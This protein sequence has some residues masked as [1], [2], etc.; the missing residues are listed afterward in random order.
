MAIETAI[1]SATKVMT[2]G[3]YAESQLMAK[4]SEGNLDRDAFLKLFT[5]QL[6]NQDPLSPM[7]NEAFV[8]QLAQ[9]SS[10]ESMNN[11]DN[12]MQSMAE[13]MKSDRFLLG[14]NLLGTK[15]DV[16]GEQA[17]LDERGHIS[18]T[19]N[20]EQ[21]HESLIF[22]VKDAKGKAVFQEQLFDLPAGPLQLDW[23]GSNARGERQAP[24][25]YSL[26]LTA[27]SNG[28]SMD[29]PVST[30]QVIKS[31]SWNEAKSEV[32]VE[33]SNGR[34]ISLADLEKFKY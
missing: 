17:P 9:F 21:S 25:H 32:L 5:T 11:V 33:I 6:Q 30:S 8:S 10:L 29:I 13:G 18:G 2:S 24:G 16:S 12:S 28:N 14:A 23:N 22:T 27:N 20:L 31:V 15:I 26:S 1:P 34:S 7:T 19:A 4:Q 3:E